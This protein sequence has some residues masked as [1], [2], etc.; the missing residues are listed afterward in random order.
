MSLPQNSVFSTRTF[1]RLYAF[2]QYSKAFLLH[3]IL[4]LIFGFLQN[5]LWVSSTYKTSLILHFLLNRVQ[6]FCIVF[7]N[8]YDLNTTYIFSTPSH[9]ILSY[10]KLLAF[11]ITCLELS[12]LSIFPHALFATQNVILW[13]SSPTS[14][15]HIYSNA[16]SRCSCNF[17]QSALRKMNLCFFL[18][19]LYLVYIPIIAPN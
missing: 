11:I 2:N 14:C 13:L 12:H 17:L 4:G 6:I 16:N 3:L 10:T 8:L 5:W 1:I 18:L 7:R 15:I 9:P 19:S